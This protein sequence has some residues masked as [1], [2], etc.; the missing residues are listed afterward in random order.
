MTQE[1][2]K[3]LQAGA[4]VPVDMETTRIL[5]NALKEALVQTQEPVKIAHRHEWF[6]TGEMKVG[7]MRC[8]SC[9]EWGQEET[10]QR[11]EQEPVAWLCKPDE[12]G[13]F[14]LPTFDKSC[15]DC[16]PVYLKEKNNG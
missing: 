11:T 12:N 10:S 3:Y 16:F 6:R 8:I 2:L 1:A 14:G 7:Q 15:K 5:V 4:I 13:L 9:G